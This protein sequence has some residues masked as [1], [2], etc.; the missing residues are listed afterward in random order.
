MPKYNGI[1]V[2]S[3]AAV[4]HVSS[5]SVRMPAGNTTG[6][7]ICVE[8]SSAVT[9]CGN[10]TA[11]AGAGNGRCIFFFAS[12]VSTPL[13]QL[14]VIG[15]TCLGGGYNQIDFGVSGSIG[16]SGVVCANNNPEGPPP[17]IAFRCTWLIIVSSVAMSALRLR[18]LHF[19]RT[20]ARSAGS[21]ATVSLQRVRQA[22][23]LAGLARVGT[24]RATFKPVLLP[25]AASPSTFDGP[26]SLARSHRTQILTE[27][28]WQ[29]RW[30]PSPIMRC[31]E[32]EH[33]S[34]P[35]AEAV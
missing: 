33:C 21:S 5:N 25:A 22:P 4:V 16:F 3:S 15:N 32:V 24:T 27:K 26:G 23:V 20:R 13:T 14:S 17:F 11:Q 12:A 8:N 31:I 10:V 35:Y 6:S 34:S 29:C 28:L 2:T 1:L 30:A 9:V 19:G 18:R 7:A